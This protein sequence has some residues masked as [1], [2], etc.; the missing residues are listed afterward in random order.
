[1]GRNGRV[2]RSVV[3]ALMGVVFLGW[4]SVASAQPVIQQFHSFQPLTEGSQPNELFQAS[5]GNFY[6][7]TQMTASV[8]TVAIFKM[9]P[10]GVVT[11]MS[12]FGV[13]DGSRPSGPLVRGSD[14]NFYA[15]SQNGLFKMSPDGAITILHSAAGADGSALSAPLIQAA[16][17]SLYGVTNW[18]GGP[19]GKGTAFRVSSDG[20]YTVLHVFSGYPLDASSITAP[21][22]QASDGSFLGVSPYGGVFDLGTIF[23]MT[24]D[25]AVTVLHAF[26]GGAGGTHPNG[27]LIAANDGNFYGTISGGAYG[28]GAIFRVTLDGTFALMYSF[29][30]PAD[31]MAMSS[32]PLIQAADGNIYGTASILGQSLGA[33]FRMTLDG[34]V[35]IFATGESI[36]HL[37]QAAD[38]NFYGLGSGGA[39]NGGSVVRVVSSAPA[40]LLS[41]TPGST[42]SQTS[43]IFTWNAGAGAS[44]YRLDVGTA[45]GQHDL[46]GQDLGLATSVPVNGL[47]LTH[48]TIYV[49]LSTRLGS[50]WQFYDYT[51]TATTDTKATLTSPAGLTVLPVSSVEF[52][53]AA[54]NGAIEYWLDVGTSPGAHDIYSASAGTSLSAVVTGLPVFDGA[55]YV[56]LWTRFGDGS[57]HYNDYSYPSY[58]PRATLT[59]PQSGSYFPPSAPITFQWTPVPG[60]TAYWLDVG[61]SQGQHDIYSHSVGAT[62]AT[63]T[64]LP[65]QGETVYVRLWTQYGGGWAYDDYQYFG[66][67]GKAQMF[68]PTP[69]SSP[70]GSSITF[71]WWAPLDASAFWLDVGTAPGLHDLFGQNMGLATTQTVNG[72]PYLVRTIWVRLWTQIGSR[73]YYT[74]YAYPVVSHKATMTL[75]A[76]GSALAGTSAAFSWNAI[77]GASQYWLEVGNSPG[78]GTYFEQAVG[79]AT[80]QTVNNLPTVGGTVYVRLWTLFNGSWLFNDFTYQAFDARAAMTTPAPGAGTPLTGTS[81]TFQWSAG[82]GA[83]AYWIDVGT[84][85]GASNL[86]GQSVGLATSQIVNGLPADGSAVYVRLWS[87]INGRWLFRDY[88]YTAVNAKASMTSPLPGT[89]L[90]GT[91]V[92]FI[93]VAAAGATSYWLDVATADGT[94]I[95]SQS[96]GLATSL[97][98][99]GLPA[100][101]MPVSVRLWTERSGSWVFNDYTYG[102]QDST[103][104]ITTPAPGSTLTGST[105]QFGWT[106]IAGATEYWLEVGTAP[107]S[108]DIFT[109]SAGTSTNQMVTGLPTS[110]APV[111]VRLWTKFGGIWRYSDATYTEVP[112]NFHIIAFAVATSL[113]GSQF[114]THVESTFT[115]NATATW[116]AWAYIT[117]GQASPYVAFWSAPDTTTMGQLTIVPTTPGFHFNSI[118]IYSETTTSVPY[119][120]TGI[121]PGGTVFTWTGMAPTPVR[122]FVHLTNPYA[123]AQIDQLSIKLTDL[124]P[125][126]N[127]NYV[128]V[129]NIV[130]SY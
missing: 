122:G 23:R 71:T 63:V 9:T 92:T 112:P 35:T 79:L 21:L 87:Q 110:V 76:S 17:G 69:G 78:V 64:G 128:G 3:I 61:T 10:D 70:T 103:A 89:V 56:R 117:L 39:F 22:V 51:Y 84:S 99:S 65:F 94:S 77:A 62:G 74:D 113:N 28:W 14:G 123:T 111:Y 18:G 33:V 15:T 80:S 44:A 120:I 116:G 2:R 4:H 66:F 95:F 46:L 98:V 88:I 55:I 96:A 8:S 125:A 37:M 109:Q 101:G 53:W 73:W 85:P 41:P 104:V 34:A 20:T 5:D 107:G 43:V 67:A 26:E 49:R 68:S 27:P 91:D 11:V 90:G 42:L 100:N 16:D 121:G 118:D 25:G 36:G 40:V 106:Q 93:W 114:A 72:L 119:Q 75:P 32:G 83:T 129:D 48:K 24:P 1:M 38:G 13:P 127:S 130:L 6:G 7:M 81:V 12:A 45:P 19:F 82:V 108:S 29:Q 58:R 57:W 59:F 115:V 105:A 47:P 54:G 86:F 126:S 31:G 124:A 52:D 60:A 50:T 102:T 97:S 30:G